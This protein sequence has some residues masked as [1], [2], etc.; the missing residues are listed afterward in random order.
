MNQY[1]SDLNKDNISAEF[2]KKEIYAKIAEIDSKFESKT[3]KLNKAITE[4]QNNTELS[5]IFRLLQTEI[6]ERK[7]NIDKL[8]KRFERNLSGI[9][10]SMAEF[11]VITKKFKR[12]KSDLM[13]LKN[14][15]SKD[16]ENLNSKIRNNHENI[17]SIA[18]FC[19]KIT[20]FLKFK[21]EYDV[22]KFY[23]K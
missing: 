16:I 1:K 20:E 15:F 2:I 3:R 10:D 21:N 19:G 13:I 8:R 4:I 9:E 18:I 7:Q 12:D 5:E 11:E 14:S 6:Q 22:Y 23:N 17:F